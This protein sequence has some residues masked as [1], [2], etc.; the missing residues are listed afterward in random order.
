MARAITK[1]ALCKLLLSFADFRLMSLFNFRFGIL[2]HS[3][4]P[5]HKLLQ[6]LLPFQ[7][8]AKFFQQKMN[9]RIRLFS[10][11]FKFFYGNSPWIYEVIVLWQQKRTSF[12]EEIC[13]YYSM[14]FQS[15]SSL[16]RWKIWKWQCKWINLIF[17][18]TV[19]AWEIFKP[20]KHQ[21]GR[22]FSIFHT[23]KQSIFPS[24]GWQMRKFSTYA[25]GLLEI[26]LTL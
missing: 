1:V 5:C 24:I 16:A 20:L 22:I 25:W 11:F 6:L 19:R 21:V 12:A 15:I 23:H 10:I 18:K 7:F 9:I 4:T 13:W 17:L 8:S 3:K 2:P 26:K 14:N